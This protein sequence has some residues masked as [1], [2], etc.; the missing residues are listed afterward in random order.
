MRNL[1]LLR[2]APASG[3]STWVK[4]NGL[5]PYTISSDNIRLLFRSPTLNP[6]GTYEISQIDNGRVWPT[7]ISLVENRMEHGDLI[8]VD[9]Q[10]LKTKEM[11]KY[12]KLAEKYRYRIYII[13]FTDV[14]EEEC[15]DR[16][17][18]RHTARVPEDVIHKF[19]SILPT[20]E[21][22]AK[23]T[24]INHTDI[25]AFSETLRAY[26]KVNLDGYKAVNVFGDIHGCMTVL[27]EYFNQFPMNDEEFYI[28]VGD[29]ID[30][31]IENAEVLS[32]LIKIKDNP[33]VI[34]LEG[35]HE[36]WIMKYANEDESLSKTFREYT[37]PEINKGIED[38][39]F[40]KKEL[41][42]LYRKC[43]QLFDFEYHG[44]EYFVCHGGISNPDCRIQTT[45][46]N[47]FIK[48]SG[49]YEDVEYSDS[50]WEFYQ[51]DEKEKVT[52]IHG[53]RAW[54]SG[55]T[56]PLE[57][58]Y[59]L[60]SSVEF[61][62]NLSV[63]RMTPEG[64][65]VYELP[66]KVFRSVKSDMFI[67][68]DTPIEQIVRC[69]RQNKNITE[70]KL[71]EDISSFNFNNNAFYRGVW[72]SQTIHSRG[73]FIDTKRNKIVA[74]GFDKFFNIG[75]QENT[76]LDDLISKFSF[77]VNVYIKENGFLG[78]MGYHDSGD[79][80]T[81][82]LFLATKTTNSGTHT[83]YFKRI[84]WDTMARTLY[85]INVAAQLERYLMGNDATILFEVIDPINDPH[86]IEYETPG[87]VALDVV[88]NT[89]EYHSLGRYAVDSVADKM[90][91]RRKILYRT[92]ENPSQLVDFYN[93][94]T[95][96]GF[97]YDGHHIEGFV[98]EDLNGYMVK[99]K[100]PFYNYWKGFRSI[101]EMYKKT[102]PD[103]KMPDSKNITFR[104]KKMYRDFDKNTML[105]AYHFLKDFMMKSYE[106]LSLD[107]FN[108]I[109]IIDVRKAYGK[110]F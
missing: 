70:K 110:D 99:L 26:E 53:H 55:N 66:N 90:N 65:T 103:D 51:R 50:N 5:E 88:K 27:N 78:I 80:D 9:A 22:S 109:N 104:L 69:L 85:P 8:I 14:P 74:R 94:V 61:G 98:L 49:G 31:G 6:N 35:N 43:R 81:S 12:R 84:F 32:F 95:D 71:S 77:P 44:K 15:L 36:R 83:D 24:V 52:L 67:N 2:G 4:E 29:Y 11:R 7:I 96:L 30:R 46:T 101:M 34:L 91:I 79:D 39:L 64:N 102:L 40:K 3:K 25:E 92:I 76:E 89:I 16:N 45:S 41:K 18:K 20:Q 62:G 33:N 21:I 73:L 100:L 37:V 13:D 106:T 107:G 56:H 75:E 59:S 68:D 42:P 28:F 108:N 60:E 97:T 38:G 57:Y 54:H 105:D 17:D 1:Y 72:S 87:L 47:D 19:Y 93:E 48:G 63:L 10:H 23:F 58:V 82:G 86:I